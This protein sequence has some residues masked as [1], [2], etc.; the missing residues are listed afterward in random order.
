MKLTQNEWMRVGTGMLFCSP[1][2]SRVLLYRL[3]DIKC[4]LLIYHDRT[5]IASKV[6]PVSLPAEAR[7]LAGFNL[8]HVVVAR[9]ARMSPRISV[10]Y[11]PTSSSVPFEE[12]VNVPAKRFA[13]KDCVLQ[14]IN[15]DTV[16]FR[17]EELILSYSRKYFIVGPDLKTTRFVMEGSGCTV[18]GP[19][20]SADWPDDTPVDKAR[21]SCWRVR[22]Y[23]IE[24]NG[25]REISHCARWSVAALDVSET[26]QLDTAVYLDGKSD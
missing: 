12:L 26:G 14:M 4:T 15:C 21:T 5:F 25:M 18:T 10:H 19:I 8:G 3:H 9:Q 7:E 11:C 6:D 23:Y 17:I 2:L 22:L 1:F 20:T 16:A 13:F 24:S